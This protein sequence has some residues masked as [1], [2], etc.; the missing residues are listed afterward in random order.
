MRLLFEI[1][2]KDYK[3]GWTTFSRPSIRGIILK[4]K[5]IAMI[6]SLKYDYYKLPGGGAEQGE[7]QIDTL[8]RE[9]KEETGLTVIPSSVREYGYVHRIQ[10]GTRADNEIFIQDNFY[11][12]CEAEDNIEAQRLEDNEAEEEFVLEFVSLRHAIEVNN[13]HNHGESRDPSRFKVKL[14][15]ETKLFELL[16]KEYGDMFD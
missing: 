13:N 3:E 8:I 2:K 5:K 15:R 6:H 12:F 4:D 9:V 1:D 11:Y 16:I 14:E 10:K 7:S